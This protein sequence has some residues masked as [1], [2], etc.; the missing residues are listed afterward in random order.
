MDVEKLKKV[1]KLATTLRDKGLAEG[2]QEAAML[3]GQMNY[4][5]DQGME[6]IFSEEPK[7]E[8]KPEQASSEEQQKPEMQEVYK[9]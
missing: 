2:R 1:N 7:E 9:I 6:R 8:P 3:A 4:E 5:D